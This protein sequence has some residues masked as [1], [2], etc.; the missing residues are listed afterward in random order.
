LL[1]DGCG[2]LWEDTPESLGAI[3]E[4][5]RLCIRMEWASESDRLAAIHRKASEALKT[6]W[7]YSGKEHVE[8]LMREIAGISSENARG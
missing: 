2:K 5:G 7:L 4:C 8:K 3:C 6:S 1:C